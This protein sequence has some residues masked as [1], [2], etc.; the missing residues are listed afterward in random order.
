M[1]NKTKEELIIELM[2]LRQ[3]NISLKSLKDKHVAEL[4]N[5]DK[6]L[7][8][9]NREKEKRADELGLANKELAFQNEE[10][11]KRADELIIANKELAY[12]NEQKEK[13]LAELVLADKELVFQNREKEKRADELGLANKELAF[14]NEEKEKRADELIIANKELAYQN[15]QKEKRLA[16]LIIADKELVFQSREKE[17]RAD[18]LIIANRE[19]AY[20]NEQKEKRADELIIANKELA[21]ENEQKEKRAAELV[22]INNELHQLIQLNKDKDKFFSIIAHD[23]RAPFNAIVGIGE[24]LKAQIRKKEFEEIE[25][26]ANMISQSSNKAMDLLMSLMAWA[27]SQSGRMDFKMEY[28]NIVTLID[29]VTFLFIDITKQKR[30]LVSCSLPQSIQV[31]AD[32][33]MISTVL[34]NLISNAIKFTQ[35]EGKIVVSLVAKQDELIFSVSDTGVGISKAGIDKLFKISTSFS[36]PG[37]LNEKGSGLGLVLCKEFI[38][39]NKGK[40]WVDDRVGIGTTI[41]FSLPLNME[42]GLGIDESK[43]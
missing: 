22:I 36:T 24:I 26:L 32:K 17:K 6:N 23:L 41:C 30:I 33:E 40:I 19:L 35:P 43:P 1:K 28:F 12:Q 38:E 25:E 37:T 18:E 3:K 8:F 11:E 27:Q 16:E 31:N 39:K 10:K 7:A 20:Q 4:S 14:Q 15:E 2:E 5:A 42:G 21:Y 13:R 34:R 9:Q 29:E